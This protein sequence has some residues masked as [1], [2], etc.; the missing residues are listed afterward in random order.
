MVVSDSGPYLNALTSEKQYEYEEQAPQNQLQ[1]RLQVIPTQESQP[2]TR[3]F[4]VNTAVAN[5]GTEPGYQIVQQPTLS[6]PSSPHVYHPDFQDSVPVTT[7]ASTESGAAGQVKNIEDILN[8]LSLGGAPTSTV[9]IGST[10]KRDKTWIEDDWRRPPLTISEKGVRNEIVWDCPG[11]IRDVIY[12]ANWFHLPDVPDFLVCTRCFNRLVQNTVLAPM[13]QKTQR[14]NGRCRFN[15]PRITSILL[16]Q[17]LQTGNIEPLKDFMLQR[18]GIKDCKAHMGMKGKDG[19]KWFVIAGDTN[20]IMVNFVSC[21]A[22]YE[23]IIQAGIYAGEFIPRESRFPNP[24]PA[25][26]T[27]MCDMHFPYIKRSIVIFSRNKLPFSDWVSKATKRF[28]VPRCEGKVVESSSREW[29]RPRDEV[30]G[31]VICE[32]CYFDQIAWTAIE[33]DF[34][35]IPIAKPVRGSEWLDQALGYRQ[36]PPTAW[37]CDAKV[38]AIAVALDGA[39]KRQDVSIFTRSARKIL[40]CP[41]CTAEGMSN[42][43]WYTLKG[44]CE[45][46]DVCE[47]C[48]VAFCE[49]FDCAQFW[50]KSP[51][52]GTSKR[53]LC[54]FHSAAP[55]QLQFSYSLLEAQVEGDWSVFSDTVRKYVDLPVCPQKTHFPNR[56]WYGWHDCL[57]CEECY[58]EVCKETRGSL[59]F[60]VEGEI[61][62][63]TRMCCMYSPRMR[64]KWA[65]ACKQGD[66]T[67]LVEFSRFRHGVYARTVPQ[68]EMLR[69][70]QQMQMMTAMSAGFAGLMYQGAQSIQSISG[71]TDGY[72]HGNSSVGWHETENGVASA[73]KFNEMNDGF[74]AASSGSSWM[75]I[76]QLAAEWDKVQ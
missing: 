10:P 29:V 65:Q 30:N 55:R 6:P 59:K 18:L 49:A 44:G 17:C 22:C 61:I 47:S 31:L 35:Y 68:M 57:I 62:E 20:D 2:D 43:T 5:G 25:E 11:S 74:N 76:F 21:E 70:M 66:A 71:N 75:R 14:I 37:T 27:W 67:E 60:E 13:F 33:A 9:S 23:D 51:V 12:E 58:Q 32:V 4:P 63:A 73:E 38:H 46:Y 52:S 69:Q 28:Q 7:I 1:I 26:D 39:V 56:K 45:N 19:I 16:P 15:V 41:P 64:E 53:I 50:E 54:N 8:N 36:D 72:L 3:Q 34:E 40:P 24:H 42:S 48:Y